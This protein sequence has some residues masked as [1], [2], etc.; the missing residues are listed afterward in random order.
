MD[1]MRHIG[2]DLPSETQNSRSVRR[3][4]TTGDAK[5]GLVSTGTNL[6]QIVLKEMKAVVGTKWSSVRP[7]TMSRSLHRRMRKRRRHR[8][9]YPNASFPSKRRPGRRYDCCRLLRNPRVYL[10]CPERRTCGLAK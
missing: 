6:K 3:G 2:R 5:S 1:Y 4:R 10:K 9:S 8:L 7:G